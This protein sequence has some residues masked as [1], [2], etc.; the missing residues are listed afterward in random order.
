MLGTLAV[1][2]IT[3]VLERTTLPVEPGKSVAC[4]IRLGNDGRD[5]V[6]VRLNVTGAGRPFSWLAPETLVLGPGS[7]AV[8]RVGFHLPRASEPPAGPLAFELTVSPPEPNAP[9]L[10]MA[11]GVVDV[12]PFSVISATLSEASEPGDDGCRTHELTVGNRGNAAVTTALRAEAAGDIEVRVDP[13]SVVAVPGSRA[14]AT[15]EV[16]AKGRVTGR[17]GTPSTFRVVV[18]PDVGTPVVVEGR[19]QEAPAVTRR[20]VTPLLVVAVVAVAAL[21]AVGLALASRGSSP[22]TDVVAGGDSPAANACPAKG[23]GDAVGVVRGLQP[24]EIANLPNSFS[25]LRVGS[26]GCHPVRFNPCEPVHFVQNAAAA[27]PAVAADVREAFARLGRTTGITFVDDGLTDENARSG[28]YVPARYGPRWAP[29]LIVWERFPPEQTTGVQQIL[30]NTNPMRV[31]DVTVSA[32]L[33]FNLAAYNDEVTQAPIEPGFGPPI[34]SGTGPI[35]RKNITWGRIV[36][37][38]LAHVVG[39]GHTRDEGSIMYPDAAQQTAR[40]A[41]FKPPDLLGLR[42]LGRE[43][44]CLTTPPL[45]TG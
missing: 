20:R 15:V 2:A 39:L 25:F 16:A 31:G 1:V 44:G 14:S 7:Q 35:G 29:I 37:H 26:D 45:P 11:A 18:E 23:H 40:P 28:P 41:D 6:P 27:P 36:L 21:V 9:P 8:A 4:D 30:G 42:Y 12:A 32:R 43:A 33:R 17:D 3:A 19:C 13:A 10:A 24:D 22:A 34:G 5:P 38:E